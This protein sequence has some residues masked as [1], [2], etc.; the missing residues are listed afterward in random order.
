MEQEKRGTVLR[1]GLS[2]EDREPVYLSRTEEGWVLHGLF[3]SQSTRDERYTA[4]P[5]RHFADE[6]R[7]ERKR[8]PFQLSQAPRLTIPEIG[9]GVLIEP[10]LVCDGTAESSTSDRLQRMCRTGAAAISG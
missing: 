7:P 4:V 8:A 6:D 9:N 3:L 10:C 5:D 2:V 1:A